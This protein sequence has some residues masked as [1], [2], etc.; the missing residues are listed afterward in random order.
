LSKTNTW[1]TTL[2]EHPKLSLIQ[3]PTLS[4]LLHS[5]SRSFS[6]TTFLRVEAQGAITITDTAGGAQQIPD[7]AVITKAVIE[8][9]TAGAGSGSATVAIGITGNTDAFIGATA[10]AVANYS[11]GAVLDMTYRSSNGNDLPIKT[12]AAR[13][14]LATIAS[15]DSNRWQVPCLC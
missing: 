12:S 4:C 2:W 5:Q 6:Y 9:E 3:L 10:G 13:N 15:A 7:N 8:V 1:L 11:T 14:V